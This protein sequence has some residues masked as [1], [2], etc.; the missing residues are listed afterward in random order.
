MFTKYLHPHMMTKSTGERK[1]RLLEDSKAASTEGNSNLSKIARDLFFSPFHSRLSKF[2][3]QG[4]CARHAHLPVYITILSTTTQ[5]GTSL[6]MSSAFSTV[7]LSLMYST[8]RNRCDHYTLR[9]IL[10]LYLPSGPSPYW[11]FPDNPCRWR[12]YWTGRCGWHAA[13]L[14]RLYD[15]STIWM[16][17]FPEVK[18][19]SVEYC[20]L[21]VTRLSI[22][23]L[24][25]S[26]HWHLSIETYKSLH[27]MTLS[28]YS[29]SHC[30]R[31]GR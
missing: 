17:Y 5:F 22:C 2:S 30:A 10:E 21:K 24:A 4:R 12:R 16:L 7:S 31:E 8:S 25:I 13:A 9:L 15:L 18:R 19:N 26:F 14:K 28:E 29:I 27:Q 23:V 3:F 20:G 6:C 11:G 1:N